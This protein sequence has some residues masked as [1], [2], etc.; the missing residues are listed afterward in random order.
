M[1]AFGVGGHITLI[2]LGKCC[3]KRTLMKRGGGYKRLVKAHRVRQKHL[4]LALKW[5]VTSTML[6]HL[7]VH[8]VCIK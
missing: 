4:R 2:A 7:S 5:I 8:Y 6:Q 1:R 3:H